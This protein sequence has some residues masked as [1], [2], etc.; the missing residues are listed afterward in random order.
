MGI[1]PLLLAG[2]LLQAPAPTT[3]PFQLELP[4]GYPG[5]MRV[6][7]P[8]GPVWVSLR[9]DQ[10]AQFEIRHFLLAAPAARADLVAANIRKERCEPL[11]R[12]FG[13]EIKV[14]E[15]SWAGLT[16]A[17][18]RID[19]VFQD[20]SQTI[21]QRLL[22]DDDHLV[23]GTWEG[24]RPSSITAEKALHSFV[25]PEAWRA[26]KIPVFDEERGLGITA[27]PLAPLGHFAV[28]IDATDPS[29]EQVGFTLEF[30]PA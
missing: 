13:N 2:A 22:V 3:P 23:V 10:H 1:A 17:G 24:D 30:T 15:G 9:E 8:D 19:Y 14:W 6:E 26:K 29:W 12:G 5:F 21:I 16:A 28:S 18:H 11:M 20:R 27:E 7:T 4:T 25:L